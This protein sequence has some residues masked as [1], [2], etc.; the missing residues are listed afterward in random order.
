MKSNRSKVILIAVIIMIILILV[1]GGVFAYLALKT[2]LLKSNQ[3]LFLEYADQTLK[4][5]EEAFEISKIKEVTDEIQQNN[6]ISNTT[7]SFSS[8]VIDGLDQVTLSMDVKN[9][10]SNR[11]LYGDVKLDTGVEDI[12]EVEY[13]LTEDEISLRLT[14]AVQQF[15]TIQN[16]DVEE[17]AK[18]LD[19]EEDVL[20]TVFELLLY[21]DSETLIRFSD[22]EINTLKETFFNIIISN[23]TKDNFKKQS[24]VMVTINGNTLTTNTYTLTI[25]PEQYK[26]ILV[27]LVEQL[28]NDSIILAKLDAYD[29]A[30]PIEEVEDEYED[31]DVEVDEDEDEYDYDD[32]KEQ[33]IKQA[34]I[35]YLDDVLTQ[36]KEQEF[37][38]DIV[39]TIYEQDG[40]TVRMKIEKGFNTITIDTI[41]NDEILGINTKIITL[42]EDAENTLELNLTKYKS[43]YYDLAL[44]I[45][46]SEIEDENVI[47]EIKILNDEDGL[48]TIE[49][50][51]EAIM[52]G[53]TT[54]ATII[55]EIYFVEEISD[56]M[57]LDNTN[58]ITLNKQTAQRCSQI[59][60][61]V[62]NAAIQRYSEPIE[63][64]TEMIVKGI[65][66]QA[67]TKDN[68]DDFENDNNSFDNDIDNDNDNDF[69]NDNSTDY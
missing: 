15:L 27:K 57:V 51:S 16:E 44:E 35:D 58:N 59:L 48:V 14:N 19:V 11:K 61:L 55:S 69:D 37:K 43:E 18:K 5:F 9:D 50:T 7:L 40:Q 42:G 25:T 52:N 23:L 10:V 31:T 63:T 29:V 41:E 49:F 64:I 47:L 66:E 60:Q 22:E 13:M 12:A 53:D 3:D 34:Y 65:A 54:K 8:D 4:K 36:I 21:K 39:V 1:G 30:N 33:T 67:V 68:D 32:E 20:N 2:D 6:S 17:L 28:K 62:S 45:K 38:Y 26:N 56:M 46:D 24:D